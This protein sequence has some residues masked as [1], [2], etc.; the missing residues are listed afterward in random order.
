M[1]NNAGVP[2]REIG[3]L[4]HVI[5]PEMAES[6]QHV[7]PSLPMFSIG[8]VS[9]HTGVSAPA[10]RMWEERYGV[11][12]PYRDEYG[13]R[14]YSRDQI[15]DLVWVRD[16]ISQGLTA[17]EAHRMLDTRKETGGPVSQSGDGGGFRQWVLADYAW[18][19]DLCTASVER[20]PRALLAYFAVHDSGTREDSE[21]WLLISC[22]KSARPAWF[23]G[24][25]HQAARRHGERLSSGEMV[26]F[27]MGAEGQQVREVAA[28]VM[29]EGEWTAT[30]ALVLA[31]PD[32]GGTQELV[33]MRERVITR[34][35]A[36]KA[37]ARF[38]ELTAP[39]PDEPA[40]SA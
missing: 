15:D 23:D 25:A 35:K 10:L 33:A 40:H 7:D 14:L 26:S 34:Y 21:S 39:D 13:K 37:Y 9:R 17:A 11:I 22:L 38:E 16:A 27:T 31:T 6:E 29:M 8:T 3:T 24:S 20:V 5:R 2:D 19:A 18:L 4:F 28:P 1:R 32:E 12:E 36:W 30:V